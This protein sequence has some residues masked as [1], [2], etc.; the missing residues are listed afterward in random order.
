MWS[1]LKFTVIT[2]LIAA[3]VIAT[4]RLVSGYMASLLIV[5][6]M[7]LTGVLF[8]LMS[9]VVRLSDKRF[10]KARAS[11]EVTLTDPQIVLKSNNLA[12]RF[13]VAG[14]PGIL[15]AIIVGSIFY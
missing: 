14:V 10:K 3:A 6:L 13:L 7:F 4:A 9:T 2:N 5:D 8:W 15:G 1:L 11:H 12:T